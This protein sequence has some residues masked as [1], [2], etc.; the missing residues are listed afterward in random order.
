MKKLE[1]RFLFDF[2]VRDR[3][4]SDLF[5]TKLGWMYVFIVFVHTECLLTIFANNFSF[6]DVSLGGILNFTHATALF[7]RGQLFVPSNRDA[8]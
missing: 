1:Y 4:P 5:Q 3:A 2:R 6:D 8:L 7:T